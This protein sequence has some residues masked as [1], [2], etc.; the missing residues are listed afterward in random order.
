MTYVSFFEQ[1]NL[2]R[3]RKKKNNIKL[4]FADAS[5]FSYFQKKID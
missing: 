4:P 5:L 1:I 3:E 2:F